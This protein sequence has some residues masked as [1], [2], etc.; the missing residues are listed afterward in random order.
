MSQFINANATHSLA[1]VTDLTN[2]QLPSS[3]GAVD[4][5]MHQAAVMGIQDEIMLHAI[6]SLIIHPD[7]S[8][9]AP[10]PLVYTASEWCSVS[11]HVWYLAH[12]A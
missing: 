10:A 11:G 3:Q 1:L 2:V 6:A 12:S 9:F 8:H 7:I 4:L 5:V